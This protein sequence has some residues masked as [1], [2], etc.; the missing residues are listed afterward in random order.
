MQ[1]NMSMNGND[2]GF[3]DEPSAIEAQLDRISS[4]EI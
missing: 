3:A 4:D 2:F 1:H